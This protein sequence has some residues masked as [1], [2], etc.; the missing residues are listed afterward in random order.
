MEENTLRT[1]F[2]MLLKAAD[3]FRK[4]MRPFSI[5]KMAGHYSKRL[6]ELILRTEKEQG[7]QY[8]GGEFIVTVATAAHFKM[9]IDLYF[10][11]KEKE[12]VRVQ[13]ESGLRDLRYLNESSRRELQAKRKI[14]FE[15]Q[16]PSHDA[17]ALQNEK[18]LP[19]R[20]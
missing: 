20:K 3:E 19:R 16:E 1:Y 18:V 6:D 17:G 8:V 12:W 13:T 15:V 14:V 11:N 4:L 10:Q 2:S 9:A 7:L 5:D